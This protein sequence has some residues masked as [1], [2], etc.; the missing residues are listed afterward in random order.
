MEQREE[1]KE[2]V[3]KRLDLREDR[4]TSTSTVQLADSGLQFREASVLVQ[5]ELATV[6]H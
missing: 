2:S 6:A 3:D 1:I 5:T 4:T